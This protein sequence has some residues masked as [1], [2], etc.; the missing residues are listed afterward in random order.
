MCQRPSWVNYT[1]V[2]TGRD[3]RTTREPTTSGDDDLKFSSLVCDSCD[4]IVAGHE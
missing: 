1:L 4:E 2:I 3:P